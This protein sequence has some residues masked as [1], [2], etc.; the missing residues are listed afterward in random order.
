MRELTQQQTRMTRWVTLAAAC[1]DMAA[2]F[3]SLSDDDINS[4]FYGYG[5]R[6]Q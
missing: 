3:P 6:R 1:T 2:R 5:S 4:T